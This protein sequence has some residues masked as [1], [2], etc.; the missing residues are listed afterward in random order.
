[1]GYL[2]SQFFH[3]MPFQFQI[4]VVL[5]Q[6][7][8]SDLLAS[9]FPSLTLSLSLFLLFF[10]KCKIVCAF[11]GIQ[12]W[13]VR[14]FNI[15]IKNYFTTKW[16]FLLAHS[17]T[18]SIYLVLVGKN[19]TTAIKYFFSAYKHRHHHHHHH[20]WWSCPEGKVSVVSIE[21]MV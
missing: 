21:L 19:I 11:Y 9:S 13:H 15:Q 1:M 8:I 10:D 18:L 16:K 12:R 4:G 14:M 17:L 20:H 3:E 5:S 2:W 6:T 7:N